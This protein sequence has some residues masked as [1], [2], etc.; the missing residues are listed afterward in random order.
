MILRPVRPQSPIGPP[1]TK[2]PVGLMKYLVSLLN[3]SA[4]RTGLMISSITASRR[5]AVEIE[6]LC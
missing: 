3:H 4:G 6:S 2:R 5:S 1:I